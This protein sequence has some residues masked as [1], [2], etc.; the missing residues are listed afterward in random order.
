[1]TDQTGHT[2]AS[3]INNLLYVDYRAALMQARGKCWST[4]TLSPGLGT[5]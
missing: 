3:G 1:M 5:W 2:Q 4:L